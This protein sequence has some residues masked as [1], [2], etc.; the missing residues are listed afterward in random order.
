VSVTLSHVTIRYGAHVA[1]RDLSVSLPRGAV[2]LLGRNGAGK[3]SVLK[4]LLGL[5]RPASG[6]LRILGLPEGF[7]PGSIRAR[8]GYMPERD[9]HLPQTTGFEMVALLGMLSGMPRRDAWRRAHEALYT[10]GLEEQRYRAIGGY[11]AG[12]RQKVKLASAL[13]HDPALLLLD[14]P[15]NGLDPE[16]R[17]EM[18]ELVRHLSHGLGKSVVLSTHI[19]Q[20]VEAVC[21]AAVV[22]EKGAVVAQGTL[23]ELTGREPTRHTMTIEPPE[24]TL[25]T[26]LEGGVRVERGE[27][28][29]HTVWMSDRA[30][31][32]QVFRAVRSAGARVRSFEPHRSSLEEVF[33]RA[34]RPEGTQ[35][36]ARG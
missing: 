21:D 29:V 3:T 30:S 20:D 36:E 19:L 27:G 26:E 12:M 34:I 23:Q 8:V 31:A 2:G 33:L 4:A 18:L 13:V 9:A 16:G 24:S 6:S 11:S 28:G 10:V 25:P 32:E 17:A 7:D 35:A 5:V 15:T 1:V 14:E 22:I